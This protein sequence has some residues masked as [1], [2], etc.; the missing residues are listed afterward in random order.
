MLSSLNLFISDDGEDVLCQDVCR[1]YM[2]VVAKEN[3]EKNCLEKQ[4]LR[5][6][7]GSLACGE[8]R[9]GLVR[10]SNNTCTPLDQNEGILEIFITDMKLLRIL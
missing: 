6:S 7:G 4:N 1:R 2:T 8:Y 10:S 5:L 9:A 3:A